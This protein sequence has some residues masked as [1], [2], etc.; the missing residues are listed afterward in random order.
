MTYVTTGRPPLPAAS[1][2]RATAAFVQARAEEGA[3]HL[4]QRIPVEQHDTPDTVELL[5]V[6]RA[7]GQ[8]AEAA[9]YH[10]EGELLGDQPDEDTAHTL[11]QIL[12]DTAHPFHTHPDLPPNVRRALKEGQQVG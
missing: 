6:V 2:V 4:L 5:H 9:A 3:Q 8:A 7:L 11:W 10:L 1:T 12:L